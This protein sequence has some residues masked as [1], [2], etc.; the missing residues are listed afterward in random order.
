[1]KI[2]RNHILKELTGPFILSLIIFTF[3]LLMGNLVQLAEL[4]INKGVG[5]T[6]VVRLFIYLIPY[7]ACYTIPMSILTSTLLVFG[8]F[9]ADNEVTAM[10]ANGVSLY[11][12]AAPLLVVGLLISLASVILNDKILPRAHFASRRTIKEI[13][14]KRP[15]AY[16]EPGTFIKNFEKYII[17]IYGINQNKL[18]NVRI[19][20]P[21]EGKAARTIIAESG[22]LI[23]VPER[24]AIKLKLINGIS[25]EPNPKDPK[26]FY[27]LNFKTYYLTLDLSEQNNAS[28]GKKPKD[29][30]IRELKKEIRK[31]EI[32]SIDANPLL[33]EIHKK[34][35]LSFAS[36][37]FVL[38]GF[39][40]GI[41]TRRGERSITF[42]LSLGVIIVYYLLLAGGEALSLRGLCSPAIGVWFGTLLLIGAGAILT[43][44]MVE[45]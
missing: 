14:F 18:T 20:E 3:V 35:V 4:V 31:L 28:I 44:R 26:N 2:L 8:R 42:G 9:S 16:L 39:P 19:Y 27:K 36:L 40:L 17:F 12:I 24:N 13:G 34:I 6:Y 7:L 11:K 41:I 23:S 38:I 25:D 29:M 1:M 15:T 5:V 30:T 32:M 21:R 45:R 22:E 37:A 43:Y 10:R 33:T